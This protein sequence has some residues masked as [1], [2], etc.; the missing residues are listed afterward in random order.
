MN[1][2]WP[3]VLCVARPLRSV[4]KNRWWANQQKSLDQ[5]GISD[6]GTSLACFP[7]NRATGFSPTDHRNIILVSMDLF[8]NVLYLL[9]GVIWETKS[10]QDPLVQR[11]THKEKSNR[12]T[13]QKHTKTPYLWPVEGLFPALPGSPECGMCLRAALSDGGATEKIQRKIRVL[14]KRMNYQIGSTM[15]CLWK[16]SWFIDPFISST[17]CLSHTDLRKPYC[18]S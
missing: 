16:G 9:H 17:L 3:A 7:V 6:S 2:W 4:L 8:C 13:Q 10:K 11:N 15:W 5:W 18:C 14:F 12:K 1:S